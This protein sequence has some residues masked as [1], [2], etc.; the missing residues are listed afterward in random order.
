MSSRVAGSVI[1]FSQ[2]RDMLSDQIDV[3][4]L[5]KYTDSNQWST[6]DLE[7]ARR[8]IAV[9]TIKYG[10]LNHDTQKDIVFTLEEWT[11][12]S[13][14]TGPYLLYAYAR[15]MG[16]GREMSI[17]PPETE[18]YFDESLDLSLLT[19]PDER[20]ILLMLGTFWQTVARSAYESKP[21]VMINYLFTLAK[22]FSSWYV[23][24]PIKTAETRPLQ[25]TRLYF[26]FAIAR[27]L[28]RGSALCGI[29]VIDRM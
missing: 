9:A 19:R 21:S 10:M 27:I 8:A 20:E 14:S 22:A 29:S 24:C 6:G 25:V 5:A 16:I 4:F 23:Q 28:K 18:V 3:E 26:I 11:A 17:A 2:L 1:L 15:I 7:E 12:K 13:G